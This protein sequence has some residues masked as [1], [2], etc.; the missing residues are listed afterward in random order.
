MATPACA[1]KADQLLVVTVEL[2]APLVQH[3]EHADSRG[4]IPSQRKGEHGSG[5]EAALPIKVRVEAGIGVGVGNRDHVSRSGHLAG[6]ATAGRKADLR[7]GGVFDAGSHAAVE[8]FRAGVVK[9]DRGPLAV[10]HGGGRRGD[11]LEQRIQFDGRPQLAG[12]FQQMLERGDLPAGL[13]WERRCGKGCHGGASTYRE[14][15]VGDR[16]VILS[17]LRGLVPTSRRFPHGRGQLA[18]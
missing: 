3:L 6:N 15:I 17:G 11:H 8:F 4:V 14:R 10:E 2:S 12:H 9:E 1:E 7:H 16:R 13:A 18:A 5:A